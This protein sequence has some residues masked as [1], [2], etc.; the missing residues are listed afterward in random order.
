M[1]LNLCKPLQLKNPVDTFNGHVILYVHELRR[2]LHAATNLSTGH[3]II[4]DVEA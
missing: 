4:F 2:I 3:D 1:L